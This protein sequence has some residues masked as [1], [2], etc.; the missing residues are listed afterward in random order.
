M[1]YNPLQ[2]NFVFSQNFNFVAIFTM[3]Y[4]FIIHPAISYNTKYK[5]TTTTTTWYTPSNVGVVG[6]SSWECQRNNIKMFL[7]LRD[8]NNTLCFLPLFLCVDIL[9]CYCF[10]Y[11]NGNKKVSIALV[12]RIESQSIACKN[13]FWC[14]IIETGL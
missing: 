10:N 9:L 1:K 8:N 13:T 5:T 11:I 2:T 14:S 4:H 6:T 7:G 12:S 3:L